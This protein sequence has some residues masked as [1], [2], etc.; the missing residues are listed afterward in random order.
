M[1]RKN[2]VAP[3]TLR[4][5]ELT[6]VQTLID[7]RLAYLREVEQLAPE[8]DNATLV[9]AT[10]RYFM[11]K[12]PAGEYIGWVALARPAASAES[13]GAMRS[14][15]VGTA[16][17][18]I[19]DRPPNSPQTGREARLVNVFV[20]QSWRGR[21]LANDLIEACVETARRAGVHRILVDDSP[22]GRRLYE[23]AGFTV[24]NTIM[25]LVW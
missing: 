17:V 7:F 23:R 4:R 21:G 25:E 8:E 10:R 13:R 11:R 9:D 5:A 20:T 16:G 14:R 2:A 24:V 19:Y 1:D 15:A 3:F 12:M 6:D 18:F 22:A